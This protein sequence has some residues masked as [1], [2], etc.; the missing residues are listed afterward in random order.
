VHLV[1]DALSPF[2]GR[3]P[4]SAAVVC[5]GSPFRGDDAVGPAVAER[6]HAAGVAVLDCADEP[7]RL[8]DLWEG[9][10]T[11]VV[12]DALRA[13]AAPGTQHRVDVGDGPLPR[14]LR[15][16]STHALGIADALELSRVLGRAPDRVVVL[17]LEGAS[18]GVGD[19]MTP[20]V[21]DALDGLVAS[22]LDELEEESCTSGR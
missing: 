15:L 8:V 13:G 18:F 1:R 22:V 14:D 17:G 11:V 6:L 9:L 7:T 19:E 3:A 10:D 12:V 2:R 16:A 21:A 5:L 20:A 4:L